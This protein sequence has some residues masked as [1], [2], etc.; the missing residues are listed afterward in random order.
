MPGRG[1][2][3]NYKGA[4]RHFTDPTQINAQQEKERKEKEWRKARG[5][6][7][8]DEEDEDE[9]DEKKGSG[10]EEASG[11]S[12]RAVGAP[13]DMPP[14]DSESESSEE[15]SDKHK[16]IEH[17]IA[18]ENP[19]HVAQKMK[20]VTDLGK[21]GEDSKPQLTRK[22]REEVQKQQAKANYMKAHLAGKTEEAQADMARLALIRRQREEAAATRDANKK[23]ADDRKKGFEQ[24]VLDKKAKN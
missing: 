2:K 1:R 4:H 7:D 22:E 11:K 13:G 20:K 14:S 16:G 12:E 8:S 3:K 15:E 24:K 23:V 9:K 18:I 5:L 17:L 6:L 19:N 21:D 10:G